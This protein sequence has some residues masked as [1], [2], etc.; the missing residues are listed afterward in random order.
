[1]CGIFCL[2]SHEILH[3][4]RRFNDRRFKIVCS[5]S[6]LKRTPLPW[7]TRV[8]PARNSQCCFGSVELFPASLTTA[9]HKQCKHTRNK[10]QNALQ[11][12]CSS[13]CRPRCAVAAR[14]QPIVC[15]VERWPPLEIVY[16]GGC[17]PALRIHG[18]PT[19]TLDF[20]PSGI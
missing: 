4:H 15:C 18:S 3:L 13:L 20:L 9:Y 17:S 19:V 12:P 16:V 10:N 14:T 6:V 1:M 11:M 5:T 7:L 2:V 8:P